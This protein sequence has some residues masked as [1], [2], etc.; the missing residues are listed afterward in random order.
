M[1]GVGIYIEE[2]PGPKV[3]REKGHASPPTANLRQ[4]QWSVYGVDRVQR[5]I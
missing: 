1:S 2:E 3:L 4:E 5:T